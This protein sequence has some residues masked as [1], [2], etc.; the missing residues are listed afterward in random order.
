M[1]VRAL[2]LSIGQGSAVLLFGCDAPQPFDPS[3]TGEL[4]VAAARNVSELGGPT[5][6]N[7]VPASESRMDISWVD[8]S[9]NETG[10]EVHRSTSG[11]SGTFVLLTTTAA[12]TIHFADQGLS[13][14]APY[15]YK[16][17]AVRVA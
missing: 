4:T 16:V 5:G 1:R 15:C 9:S 2:A 12:K 8:N 3:G 13:L 11:E 10:F 17:R 14:S 7:A 6:A